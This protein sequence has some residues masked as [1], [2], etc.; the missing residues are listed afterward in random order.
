MGAKKEARRGLSRAGRKRLARLA[1]AVCLAL[2]FP[3]EEF[4]QTVSEEYQLK[5]V[6]LGRIPSFVDW[7]T[8]A[9]NTSKT[10][11]Q[12]CTLGDYRF[13]LR[14][15]QEVGSETVGGRRIALRPARKEQELEGCEMIFFSRSEAARYEKLLEGQRGK[16]VLTV[17]E[18]KGFLEA[19]GIVEFSFENQKLRMEVNLV[20]ARKANLKVDARL[21]A[22][23]KRVVTKPSTPGG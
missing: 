22:L 17:G 19:G 14:L 16:N 7:P 23:A 1:L 9:A 8:S 18:T 4:G 3:S 2:L 12:L 5:A 15:A 10:A 6:Y 11:F 20:A 13:G 21:L